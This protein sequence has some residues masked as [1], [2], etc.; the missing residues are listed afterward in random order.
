MT[1]P[2]STTLRTQSSR[3]TDSTSGVGSARPPAKRQ[4]RNHPSSQ[5]PEDAAGSR[6]LTAQDV[7]TIM[8]AV[9]DVLPSQTGAPC[10]CN[11]VMLKW[12]QV[13]AL[14]ETMFLVT[15]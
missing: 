9:L 13:R 12:R 10:Q 1:P 2:V 14:P 11:P 3:R 7:P 6:S 15:Y 4:R 8:Q 5:S